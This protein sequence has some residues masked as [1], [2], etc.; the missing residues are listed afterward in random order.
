VIK[1]RPNT[2]NSELLKQALSVRP[3]SPIWFSPTTSGLTKRGYVASFAI[4]LNAAISIHSELI[5]ILTASLL[6]CTAAV[7]ARP[8][9][10]Q[11]FAGFAKRG[12]LVVVASS[13]PHAV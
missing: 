13:S 10:Q 4:F 1:E 12:V 8:R 3:A 6:A 7:T 2:Q 11:G 5:S 9:T